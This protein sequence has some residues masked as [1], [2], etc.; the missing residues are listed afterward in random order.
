MDWMDWVYY[1]LLLLV[2]VAGLFLT[3]LGLP[4]LWLM[5]GACAGYAWLTSSDQ[6]VG[7]PSMI[8]LIVLGLL[9]EL[10]EFIA[11]AAGSKAAGGRKRGMIGSIIGALV[12]GIACSPIF[13]VVGTIVGACAGAFIGAAAMEYTDRDIDHAMRVGVGAAKGRLWG[14]VSKLG[15]GAIMFIIIVIAALPI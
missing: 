15:F 13:P 1:A 14:I 7:W 3:I 8:A 6:Y 11:G 9:A 5:I 2:S 10:V 12:G 4:G